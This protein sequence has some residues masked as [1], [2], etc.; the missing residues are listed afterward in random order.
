MHYLLDCGY[1][2]PLFKNNKNIILNEIPDG[3]GLV[4]NYGSV[5]SGVFVT[6]EDY[7]LI[8]LLIQ[9]SEK[10]IMRSADLI[11][12]NMKNNGEESF[13]MDKAFTYLKADSQMSIR[14]LFGSTAPFKS[15]YE[16]NG[17]TGRIKYNNTIY[18]GY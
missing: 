12:V 4:D 18:Q 14:Y 11:E 16:A 7:L 1:K 3:D 13:S 2:I 15:D 10:R 6:Y 17:V 9:G 5:N 8:L